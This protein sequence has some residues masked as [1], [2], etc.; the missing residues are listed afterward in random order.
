MCWKYFLQTYLFGEIITEFV[1][2]SCR[3]GN[4]NIYAY[5]T[6]WCSKMCITHKHNLRIDLKCGNELIPSI[7][8]ELCHKNSTLDLW[9]RCVS[10]PTT[11]V[12]SFTKHLNGSN[13]LWEGQSIFSGA[14]PPSKWARSRIYNRCM[15]TDQIQ[16]WFYFVCACDNTYWC[17]LDF[18]M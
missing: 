2:F 12:T 16:T 18:K 6:V 13:E 1:H 4:S 7:S 14:L 5:A 8:T 3:Q 11:H 9:L 15:W 10:S 17:S